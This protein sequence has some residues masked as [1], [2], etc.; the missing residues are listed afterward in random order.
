[1]STKE[2]RIGVEFTTNEEYQVIVIDYVNREQVQVMFLDEFKIKT[3]T[4]W[5]N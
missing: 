1:M 3:C 2:E 5:R 4:Q